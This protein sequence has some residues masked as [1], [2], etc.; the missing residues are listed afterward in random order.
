M[1]ICKHD[2]KEL[3]EDWACPP[4]SIPIR[5]DIRKFDF[6]KLIDSQLEHGGRL[7]DVIL[8][9]PP[10]ILASANPTRG[11]ALGYSQMSVKE[12]QKIP[13]PRLQKNGVLFLW[14]INSKLQQGMEML[15]TWGYEYARCLQQTHVAD[16]VA[17]E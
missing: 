3:E 10:W 7:F 13:L 16:S 4:H 1:L 8:M 5:A 6:G 11:V 14:V 15:E 17:L 12:I 2:S 9:D